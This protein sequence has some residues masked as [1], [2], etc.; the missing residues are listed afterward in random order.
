MR[1]DPDSRYST[2]AQQNAYFDEV[3]RRVKEV[4]GVQAAGLTDA[5][6]LG[7]NRSWGAGVKGQVYPKGQYPIA[8]VRVVSDGYVKA[9]GIPI[10]EGRDF[11]ERDTPATEPVIMI[12]ETMARRLWP[13]QSPLGSIVR[14][15]GERRVVGVVG[16][17]RHLA[18]EQGAG[19]EIYLPMRQCRDIS[20]VDLVVR[21]ALPSGELASAVRAALKPIEPNLPGNDF[22]TLQT[23]V[24]KAVSPRRFVVLLLGGFAAFAL[25]LAS[26]GIYGVIS[27]SVGQRTHEIGIRMALGASAGHLQGRIIVQTLGLAAMGMMLGGA[28]AWML[29][30]AFQGLLYEVNSS[31]PLTFAAMLAVL[32]VV[33]IVAGYLP[34]RRASRID[35]MAALRAE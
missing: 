24:D 11:T 4:P 7:R 22:R 6:P 23:L 29:A 20:S 15:C 27:Y 35:P 9:M 33:A 17:V 8:F 10:R 12:N 30:R 3:L 14:A 18:L 25:I 31:D 16:D 21:T 2:Q 13:G 28:A 5:L 19:L 34:A 32:T 26:L 1:V